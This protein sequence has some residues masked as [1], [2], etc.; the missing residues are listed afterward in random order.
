MYASSLS[1]S[2][3]TTGGS[4]VIRRSAWAYSASSALSRR[5]RLGDAAYA[6]QRDNSGSANAD[7]GS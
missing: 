6:A 5:G 3:T 7:S 2:G 1:V 4:A